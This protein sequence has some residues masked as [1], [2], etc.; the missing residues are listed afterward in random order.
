MTAMKFVS[1]HNLWD[2]AQRRAGAEVLKRVE[3]DGL[4]QVRFSFPDQHGILRRKHGCRSPHWPRLE[5]RPGAFLGWVETSMASCLAS[6]D[7]GVR[8]GQDR[9]G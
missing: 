2:D 5:T 8:P 6:M 1:R 3:A 7:A 9:R 4:E